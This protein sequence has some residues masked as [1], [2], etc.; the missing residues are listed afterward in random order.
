MEVAGIG[1]FT[2]VLDQSVI[3][4]FEGSLVRILSINGLITAK[5]TAGRKKDQ[6]GLEEL[7]ALRD[8]LQDE[9]E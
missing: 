2:A 1:D 6:A 3:V 9:S 4:D 8:A 7:Y 5:E